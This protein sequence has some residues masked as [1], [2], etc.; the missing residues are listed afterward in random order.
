MAPEGASNDRTEIDG[1]AAAIVRQALDEMAPGPVRTLLERALATEWNTTDAQAAKLREARQAMLVTHTFE[2]GQL[3]KWKPSLKNR[4]LP[5]YGSPA[6]VQEVL[7]VP[8]REDDQ[9]PSSSYFNEPLDL[10]LGVFQD[11]TFVTYYFD[12]RR[13]EPY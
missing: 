5:E 12:S 1:E 7:E 2:V 4:R 13:F 9:K 6:I 10:V 3:V 11:D 8:I